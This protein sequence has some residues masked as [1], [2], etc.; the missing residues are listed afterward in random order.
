MWLNI[1]FKKKSTVTIDFFLKITAINWNLPVSLSSEESI[2]I[3]IEERT[4]FE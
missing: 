3:A 4:H 1:S 2:L